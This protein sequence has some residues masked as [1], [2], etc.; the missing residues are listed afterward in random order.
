MYGLF[1]VNAFC[2][3][4]ICIF[5][6][7]NYIK[8]LNNILNNILNESSHKLDRA[9]IWL[10]LFVTECIIRIFPGLYRDLDDVG[11]RWTNSIRLPTLINDSLT[12]L[13][14]L[15]LEISLRKFNEDL[16]NLLKEKH[17]TENILDNLMNEYIRISKNIQLFN[18]C[19]VFTLFTLP[20]LSTIRTILISIK[21][22]AILDDEDPAILS[23]T[24]ALFTGIFLVIT[25]TGRLLFLCWCSSKLTEESEDTLTLVLNLRLI[26]YRKAT[27]Y[28]IKKLYPVDAVLFSRVWGSRWSSRQQWLI[29]MIK[30]M[31]YLE[32]SVTYIIV[33]AQFTPADN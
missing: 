14:M 26:W 11:R 6:S 25:L 17:L 33:A 9:C 2:N 7:R 1:G 3:S 4:I 27:P 24:F 12:M 29:E 22:L 13:N 16:E 28:L 18:K 20:V 32:T 31:Q 8:Q 23:S 19:Y 30:I 5:Y 15:I 21:F 10:F